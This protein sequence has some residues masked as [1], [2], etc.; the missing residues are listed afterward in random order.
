MSLYSAP[1]KI[2]FPFTTRWCVSLASEKDSGVKHTHLGMG[3]L[4]YSIQKGPTDAIGSTTLSLTN[5]A[6]GSS[7]RI[8]VASTGALASPSGSAAGVYASGALDITLDLFAPGSAENALRIKVRKG[9][10][11]PKYQPF[12]TQTTMSAAPQA[13]FVAQVIDPIA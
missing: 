10:A 3:G 9:S 1:S 8:E 6:A 12:E 4:G 5:I 13:V 11:G 7:Y 2:V